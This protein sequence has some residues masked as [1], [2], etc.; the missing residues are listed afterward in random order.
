MRGMKR[1]IRSVEKGMAGCGPA[2]S[3]AMSIGLGERGL[4]RPLVGCWPP[5]VCTNLGCC[6]KAAYASDQRQDAIIVKKCDT[7]ATP[8]AKAPPTVRFLYTSKQVVSTNI[9]KLRKGTLRLDLLSRPGVL[10]PLLC[11]EAMTPSIAKLPYKTRIHI[12]TSMTRRTV[13]RT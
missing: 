7:L 4:G 11:V 13:K 3:L 5:A 2:W 12:Q 9:S 1:G 8:S 6:P 10:T